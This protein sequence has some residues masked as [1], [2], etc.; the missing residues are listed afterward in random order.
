MTLHC[1]EK[2]CPKP[3]GKPD[4]VSSFSKDNLL[5]DM[6]QTSLVSNDLKII[7]DNI[8]NTKS[9]SFLSY[10]IHHSITSSIYS[11]F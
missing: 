6:F 10:E 4:E 1:S 2:C 7:Q 3:C 9:K 8:G 11:S 5:S